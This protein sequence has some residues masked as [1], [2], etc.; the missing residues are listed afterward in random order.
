MD[1]KI[2]TGKISKREHTVAAN[3]N[4]SV[5]MSDGVAIDIDIFQP[6]SKGKFPALLSISTFNKEIQSQHIWP[7]PTRSRRIRGMPDAVLEAPI[8]D[9]WVRRG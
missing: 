4:V 1:P 9:F 6:Q 8:A 3:R 7:A 2:G 5:Q